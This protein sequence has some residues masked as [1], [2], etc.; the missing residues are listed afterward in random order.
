MKV[1]IFCRRLLGVSGLKKFASYLIIATRWGANSRRLPL[2]AP[3]RLTRSPLGPTRL[4]GKCI[5]LRFLN[6]R[7][8]DAHSETAEMLKPQTRKEERGTLG[9]GFVPRCD[10]SVKKPHLSPSEAATF[11][12]GVI[13]VA[14]WATMM[15]QP[16]GGAACDA[17]AAQSGGICSLYRISFLW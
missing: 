11:P 5:R 6:D 7:D 3:P 1:F 14:R 4:R 17:C 16:A 10:N 15:W 13:R 8:R 2:S 9:K 12:G